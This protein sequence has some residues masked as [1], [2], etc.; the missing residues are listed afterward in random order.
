[1][2]PIK[3]IGMMLLTVE[4]CVLVLFDR[5]IIVGLHDIPLFIPSFYVASFFC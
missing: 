1:M 2:Q 5:C 4:L 3:K